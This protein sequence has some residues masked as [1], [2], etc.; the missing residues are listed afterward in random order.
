MFAGPPVST[1]MDFDESVFGPL[2]LKE[3]GRKHTREDKQT[4]IRKPA[5]SLNITRFN[6]SVLG[7]I[8]ATKTTGKAVAHHQ[9]MYQREGDES[10]LAS[11]LPAGKE[12]GDSGEY[13]KPEAVSSVCSSEVKRKRS[14]FETMM[15]ILEKPSREP[16]DGRRKADQAIKKNQAG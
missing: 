1:S 15:A 4:P 8:L 12:G 16:E 9:A 13:T 10:I 5:H 11:I 6:E 14:A 2:C 7:P 3:K